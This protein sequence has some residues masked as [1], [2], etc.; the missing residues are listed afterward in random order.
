LIAVADRV[1]PGA[2][3]AISRLHEL[4]IERVVMM[5]GDRQEV[6]ETIGSQVG[7]D[8][9]RA[10]LLPHEKAEAVSTLQA[11][12]W[13]VMQVGD[14]INDAPALATA[15]VGVAMGMGGTDVALE[16]ADLAL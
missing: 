5:T 4:G 12:G 6:A 14:G 1:R 10:G 2:D 13:G 16:S 7:V 15:N 9:I 8:D 3:T 11:E